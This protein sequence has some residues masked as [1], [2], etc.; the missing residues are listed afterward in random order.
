MDQ[1]H[2][3]LQ[4]LRSYFA[5]KSSVAV[6]FSGGVDSTLLLAVAHEV[7]GCNAIALTATSPLHPA[8]ESNE[9]CDFC[10]DRGIKQIIVESR[11]FEIEGFTHNPP[12]RCY[13][14]KKSLFSTFLQRACEHGVECVVEGSNVDDG[15]DYRPGARAVAELG[16]ESPLALCGLTKT[17]IRTLSR[18]MNLPTW[19]K[20]SFACL[21]SRFAYGDELTPDRL[22]MVDA[23]EQVLLDEGFKQVRVRFQGTTARI[24]LP[25]DQFPHLMRSDV[26]MRIVDR[27]KETGFSYVSLDLQGYRTGSMNETL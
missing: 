8:R 24:E 18:E 16:I 2:G 5:G 11:E 9:A 21:A 4:A 7:L 17:E 6:A 22:K 27:I 1:L 12:D 23:A 25:P 13:M 10:T 19:D 26:R 3:K 15:S 20:Q 14:C